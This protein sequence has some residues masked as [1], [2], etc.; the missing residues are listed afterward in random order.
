MSHDPD[1]CRQMNLPPEKHWQEVCLELG[2]VDV[3]GF[4]STDTVARFR[5]REPTSLK[6][7]MNHLRLF[8]T[9]MS[10]YVKFVYQRDRVLQS[11]HGNHAVMIRVGGNLV[12]Y[13]DIPFYE[14]I[15]ARANKA[16]QY[17]MHQ[18]ES[19]IHTWYKHALG[20]HVPQLPGE[21]A[22][23][24]NFRASKMVAMSTHDSWKLNLDEACQLATTVQDVFRQYEESMNELE[25]EYDELFHLSSEVTGL[26]VNSLDRRD[27]RIVS[28][29]TT[30]MR[31][32]LY[33]DSDV[34]WFPIFE[35]PLLYE[36]EEY[37]NPDTVLAYDFDHD[38][39]M[40]RQEAASE[41]A[42]TQGT[43]P[44]KA[45]RAG[46]PKDVN[47]KDMMKD[48]NDIQIDLYAGDEDAEPGAENLFT[49]DPM[50]EG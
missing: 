20:G 24:R 9:D 3:T 22:K 39:I 44:N 14:S 36:V 19:S 50:M 15:F 41:D 13:H 12:F 49:G 10:N 18:L 47:T 42:P 43:P 21:S 30:F 6:E 16:S 8:E 29:P 17:F 27:W 34:S 37:L 33:V 48:L 2:W 26:D 46:F 40:G 38:D 28:L 31:L 35:T 32:A 7:F 4:W 11:I 25:Q 5:P 1:V 23:Q 45:E